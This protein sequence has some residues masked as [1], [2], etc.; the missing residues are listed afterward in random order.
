MRACLLLCLALLA[1]PAAGRETNVI[2]AELAA[3]KARARQ[4][5]ELLRLKEQRGDYKAQ[6]AAAVQA[7]QRAIQHQAALRAQGRWPSP[8]LPSGKFT[9]PEQQ[10]LDQLKLRQSALEKELLTARIQTLQR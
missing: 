2:H 4:V 9:P 3:V 6:H 7:R 1:L 10:T 8:G 5:D